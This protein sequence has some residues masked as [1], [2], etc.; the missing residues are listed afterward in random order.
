M[1]NNKVSLTKTVLFTVCSILVLDSFVAPT[2]IGVSSITI[3]IITAIFFF[4]PYGLLSAELG[5]TYPD[6]GGIV[7]WVTRAFGEF[8]GVLEGWMY[9]INVAFWMPAVFTAFSGWLVLAIWPEMPVFLQAAI[10]IAMCWVIVYIGVKGID[11]SVEVASIMAYLKMGIL[12]LLGILGIIYGIKNGLANDFSLANW[13]P[14]F[15]D[16]I[17]PEDSF[18]CV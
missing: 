4:I 11:L 10:A 7:S 2:I 13:I 18:S 1:N 8:W 6:D 16:I 3:W 17:N 14:S 5:S 15:A 9:W 12:V